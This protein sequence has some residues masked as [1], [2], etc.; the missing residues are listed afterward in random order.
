[1]KFRSAGGGDE[2]EN[3]ISACPWCHLEGVHKHRS[4]KVKSPASKVEWTFGREPIFT[5]K[6]REKRAASA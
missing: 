6:G 4:V 1:M 3:M 5:V 2:D